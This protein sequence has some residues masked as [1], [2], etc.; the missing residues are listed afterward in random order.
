ME[1]GR[2]V[3]SS[4]TACQQHPGPFRASGRLGARA[5]SVH[6]HAS[7]CRPPL[8]VF[9]VPCATELQESGPRRVQGEWNL[10]GMFQKQTLPLS[11]SNLEEMNKSFHL[12]LPKN[13]LGE[14]ALLDA[15]PVSVFQ[16]FLA[17]LVLTFFPGYRGIP[18]FIEVPWIYVLRVFVWFGLTFV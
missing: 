8:A 12:K 15:F 6:P 4:E 18:E 14:K 3:T 11:P 10:L 7:L 9:S 1:A 16:H 2:W 5:V 13:Y 17:C